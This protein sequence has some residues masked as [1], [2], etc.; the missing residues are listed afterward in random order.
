MQSGPQPRGA[1]TPGSGGARL[2][3]A[4]CLLYAFLL[5]GRVATG[6][7]VSPCGGEA[8]FLGT[9]TVETHHRV[10][11]TAG[12]PEARSRHEIRS[13]ALCRQSR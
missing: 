7:D 8:M 4:V 9:C 2:P 13:R 3:R 11:A 12:P 10:G 5:L 6:T 1:A